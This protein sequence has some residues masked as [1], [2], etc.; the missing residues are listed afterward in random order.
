MSPRTAAGYASTAKGLHWLIVALLIAQFT[1]AWTMPHIGRNTPVTTLISLHFTFGIVILAVAM[2][3]LLWRLG[4]NEPEPMLEFLLGRSPLPVSCIGRSICCCSSCRCSAG[5]TGHIF[6]R[7]SEDS[8]TLAHCHDEFAN[9]G[10][11][12]KEGYR[13]HVEI[14]WWA[15]GQLLWQLECGQYVD[16]GECE[17]R[18]Q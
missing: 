10:S 11:I 7:C 14:F 18:W 15:H 1:F 13:L 9:A 4:H 12:S 6:I 3:R 17:S 8:S 5:L 2:V 16:A